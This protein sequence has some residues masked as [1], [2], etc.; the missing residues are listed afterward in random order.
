MCAAVPFR[1]SIPNLG[2]LFC[3]VQMFSLGA[4]FTCENNDVMMTI[5]VMVVVVATNGTI[6]QLVSIII[7]SIVDIFWLRSHR[8][9]KPPALMGS[10]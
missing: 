5:T 2:E 9:F 7:E 8:I 10:S 6:G 3:A 1:R 4:C